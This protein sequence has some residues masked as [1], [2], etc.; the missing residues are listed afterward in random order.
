VP[1]DADAGGF[2]FADL[3]SGDGFGGGAA[4]LGQ[5]PV[6]VVDAEG[7]VGG[8]DGQGSSS[9]DDS[10]VNALPCNGYG[11]AA[12]DPTFDLDGFGCLL[13]WWSGGS[14]VADAYLVR[15]AEALQ[16]LNKTPG[17]PHGPSPFGP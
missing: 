13:G 3:E 5:Q 1:G 7:M 17:T 16:R 8:L 10:D 6:A 9:V 12:A 4:G 11:A 2:W 14:G 15:D